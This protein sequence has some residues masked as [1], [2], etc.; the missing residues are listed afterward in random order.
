[1][2]RLPNLPVGDSSVENIRQNNPLYVDKTSHLCRMVDQGKY[3]FLS[4]PRRFGKSL[5]ISTLRCL[6]EGR[7]DLFGGLW[8]AE[9]GQWDWLEH[10]VILLD[11][12][13]ISHDTNENLHTSLARSLVKISERNGLV[14]D[15]PLGINFDTGKRNVEE[16]KMEEGA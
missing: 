4:R 5:T 10:P 16:W 2:P 1:M 15:A 8:I 13:G 11:F 7:R 6:F 14:A 12:N 9:H 3:Y